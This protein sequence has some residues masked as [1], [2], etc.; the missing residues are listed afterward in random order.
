MGNK[1]RLEAYWKQKRCP[2]PGELPVEACENCS[3]F[4]LHYVLVGREY[5][6]TGGG[7]CRNKL[8]VRQRK[9]HDHCEHYERKG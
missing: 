9:K 8:R 6:E 3:K 5:H 1:E 2:V 4:V 7:H